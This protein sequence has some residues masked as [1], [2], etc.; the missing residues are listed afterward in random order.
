MGPGHRN[1]AGPAALIVVLASVLALS[2]CAGSSSAGASAATVA[3]TTTVS[4]DWDPTK[5]P[6][7]CRLLAAPEV[8]AQF[9][10]P[11]GFG[12]RLHGWPPSCQFTLDA[13][14]SQQLNVAEDSGPDARS[15][16]TRRKRIAQRLVPVSGV[17][18]DAYWL[19]DE[20]T[21]HALSGS[22]RIYIALRSD[23]GLPPAARTH[24]T[25]LAR[26]ALR[27][28]LQPPPMPRR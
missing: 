26:I 18:E 19:P 22:T 14:T 24:A 1:R 5:R 13:R 23:T 7:P 21:L 17:G 12:Q 10:H 20:A 4:G 2:S 11:V 25:A 15:N 28:A 9:G 3:T 6:D 16:F 8:A 27:R